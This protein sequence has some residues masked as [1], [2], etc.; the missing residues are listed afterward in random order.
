MLGAKDKSRLNLQFFD[1]ATHFT[2]NSFSKPSL[3]LSRGNYIVRIA[4]CRRDLLKVYRLRYEVFHKEYRNKKFPF[5]FDKDRFDQ[6]ADHLMIIDKRNQKVVGTYRMISSHISSDFYSATEFDL[7]P[8]RDI[9]GGM[10]ELSRACIHRDYRNGV[11]VSLLWRGIC[12]YV[13][14]VGARWL[15]GLGSVK[16]LDPNAVAVIVKQLSI[17]G[18]VDPNLTVQTV[19]KHTIPDFQLLVDDAVVSG[20]TDVQLPALVRSYINAGAK[21]APNVA[22]DQDFNCI[23]LF[24]FLDLRKM[25]TLFAKKYQIH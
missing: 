6:W 7:E 4:E 11:I 10:V 23:D 15:F 12:E 19:E 20:D 14:A 3:Y 8:I 16:T 2:E 5:G 24:V 9:K 18:N 1:K 17:E 21:I 13:N 25:S 22:I